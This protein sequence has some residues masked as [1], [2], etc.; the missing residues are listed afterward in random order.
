MNPRILLLVALAT[1]TFA[2][3]QWLLPSS[4]VLSSTNGWVTVDAAVSNELFYF[5]HVPLRLTN[6]FITGPDGATVKAE[7]PATGK[8]RS[9][10]DIHLEQPGTY[11]IAMINNSMFANWTEN[12]QPKTWRGSEQAFKTEV[13]ANAEGLKVSRMNGRVET[14]VTAGK[15]TSKALQPTGAGLELVPITHPNDLVV[16]EAARFQLVRDGKPASDLEVTLIPGGIRYRDQLNE[17]KVK[18]DA[19][20]NFSVTFKSPGMY[21][22]NATVGGGP[23]GGGPGRGAPGGDRASYT[24][25]I[26]V[27]PQ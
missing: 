9:T 6:L 22:I 17:M 20:G 15:P 26:E 5:D 25:T 4:T 2:H 16:G 21:W 1:P 3:R 10:F 18:T 23:G 8:Y 11:R 27:M 24:A 13:P 7:N 12:G 14:F 19:Q